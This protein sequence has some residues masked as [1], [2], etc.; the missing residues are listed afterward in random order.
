MRSTEAISN[1]DLAT[2]RQLATSR[3]PVTF[4]ISKIHGVQEILILGL[5][6]ETLES[7]FNLEA[8]QLQVS[9]ADRRAQELKRGNAVTEL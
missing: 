4:D 5:S 2:D 1:A 8:V 6:A 9:F 7:R 3:L